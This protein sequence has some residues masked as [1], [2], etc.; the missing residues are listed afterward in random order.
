MYNTS[1]LNRGRDVEDL[2]RP[3]DGVD[4]GERGDEARPRRRGVA[5][6]LD[7]EE[8]GGGAEGAG[9][10]GG[11]AVAADQRR[12]GTVA[13]PDLR[14]PSSG[15]GVKRSTYFETGWNNVLPQYSPNK[16]HLDPR[17][18]QPAAHRRSAPR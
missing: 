18:L 4:V 16:S 5:E 3:A 14:S 9:G 6:E 13:V 11:A 15:V 12:K 17:R 8:V 7:P 10:G 1:H 2:V